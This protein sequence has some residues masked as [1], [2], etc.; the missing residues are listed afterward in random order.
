MQVAEQGQRGKNNGRRP[1]RDIWPGG[2]S[3]QRIRDALQ[4]LK[5]SSVDD[6]QYAR[7]LEETLKIVVRTGGLLTAHAVDQGTMW[8]GDAAAFAEGSVKEALDAAGR[9]GSDV[10]HAAR[11]VMQTM[12]SKADIKCPKCGLVGHAY[13]SCY[14]ALE[15]ANLRQPRSWAGAGRTNTM[16]NSAGMGRGGRRGGPQAGPDGAPAAGKF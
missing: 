6:A 1:K 11:E 13:S 3:A 2:S 15:R 4:E 12:L 5:D 8:Y 9:D 10:E 14:Q 16:M 7:W